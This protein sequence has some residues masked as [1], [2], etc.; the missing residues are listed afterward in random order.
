MLLNKAVYTFVKSSNVVLIEPPDKKDEKKQ[1]VIIVLN[2]LVVMKKIINLTVLFICL[3][4]AQAQAQGSI[5]AGSKD[6]VIYK[7]L[8]KMDFGK[9]KDKVV[10]KFFHDLGYVYQ[11]YIPT[12]RKPGYIDR[13]IFRYSDSLSV[14]IAVKD[15]GQKEP[16]N[17][18][19]KFKIEVFKARKVNWICLKYGGRCIKGCEEESCD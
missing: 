8:M 4:C 11:K 13:V 3:G 15:L 10:D 5:K 18:N 7:K 19:Y 17:F 1:G 9:Y 12:G 14:D 2:K 6:S 16:L